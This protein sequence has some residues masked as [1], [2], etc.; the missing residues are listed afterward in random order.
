MAE[1]ERE[2]EEM[3]KIKRKYGGYLEKGKRYE[4]MKQEHNAERY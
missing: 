2:R 3:R 4:W 1:R